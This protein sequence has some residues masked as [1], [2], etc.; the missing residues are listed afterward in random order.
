MT[1]DFK[2]HEAQTYRTRGRNR[3]THKLGILT[4]FFSVTDRIARQKKPS[5]NKEDWVTVNHLDFITFADHYPL[6]LQ[7][8]HLFSET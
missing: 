2:T 7:N 4:L 8:A 3:Q 6:Q 1:I 5:K